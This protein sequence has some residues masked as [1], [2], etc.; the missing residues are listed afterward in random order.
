MKT[1][2]DQFCINVSDL[3]RSVRFY[4][5]ALGLTVTH[6][7]EMPNAGVSSSRASTSTA[8]RSTMAARC[9]SST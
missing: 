4:E 8:G 5:Q 6:R 1:S 3:E 7:I 2:L 9:G